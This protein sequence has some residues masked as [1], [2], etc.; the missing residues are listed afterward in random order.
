MSIPGL[1]DIGAPIYFLH[2]DLQPLKTGLVF[3]SNFEL[4]KL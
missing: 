4:K 2:I 3:C 1:Y